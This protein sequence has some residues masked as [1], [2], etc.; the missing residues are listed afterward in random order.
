MLGPRKASRTDK[1]RGSRRA[2]FSLPL[3]RERVGVR[4]PRA[5]ER[6]PQLRWT[7]RSYRRDNRLRRLKTSRCQTGSASRSDR[8][9]T[10][11]AGSFVMI[12]STP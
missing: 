10:A 4:A 2:Y 1:H 3:L 8:T 5:R 9:A 6:S 11:A 7:A 12:P